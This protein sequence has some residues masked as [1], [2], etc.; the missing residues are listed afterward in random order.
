MGTMG[1]LQAL[2]GVK[3]IA[4]GK[5]GGEGQ[6]GGGEASMLLFSGDSTP[7]FRT[8]RLRSRRTRCFACS[9]EAGL[10]LESLTKGNLDYVL[11]CGSSASTNIL[12]PEERVEAKVYKERSGTDHLLLDI[13]EKVQ[14]D[15]CSIDGSVNVPFSTLQGSSVEF[16]EGRQPS[17]LPASLPSDAPI[18]V[19]CKLGND[20]QIVTRRL[21]ESGLDKSGRFIGDIKGGFKAWKE[22]VDSS[23]PEY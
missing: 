1:V 21:K 4:K 23:W 22:Q 11:F 8:V 16:S 17:W 3:L 6:N 7:P 9:A 14:F 20:S 18:Y 13:R 15:I 2:E 5:L 19:A 10:S 12:R